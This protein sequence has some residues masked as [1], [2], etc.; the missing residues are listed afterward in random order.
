MLGTVFSIYFD[1]VSD[2]IARLQRKCVNRFLP[3]GWTYW[4]HLHVPWKSERFP[5]AA[6][7]TNCVSSVAN[8]N[9]LTIFLDIDCIPLCSESFTH[10]EKVVNLHNGKAL[11]GAVQ[12]AN[13]INNNRH[14]YVGPCCLAFSKSHYKKLG[15]PSFIET[16]R[17]DVAEELT[18]QWTEAGDKNNKFSFGLH[19][20]S[21]DVNFLWPTSV[22]SPLWDL[23]YGFKFGLG[24]TYGIDDKDLFYHSFNVRH[25]EM[26][27]LFVDKCNSVIYSE[28]SVTNEASC[29]SSSHKVPGSP[30]PIS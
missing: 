11:V 3:K 20:Y 27:Q 18:Y 30:S 5:H 7:M 29:N 26:Q 12:R 16:T 22:H 23:E 13:H 19:Q 4:Q 21:R 24:T 25:P 6:A 17:G 10:L 9:D 28:E 1:N 2:D 14:L 15:S 8:S